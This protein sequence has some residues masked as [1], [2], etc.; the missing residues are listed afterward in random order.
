MKRR[1]STNF[2]AALALLRK[3]YGPGT[4]LEPSNPFDAIVWENCAYLVD[5]ERRTSTYNDL[6]KRIGVT[7]LGLISAGAK[8]IEA[9]ITGGGMKAAH[10][11]AKVLKC[12]EIALQFAGGNLSVALSEADD[13][14][15]RR[16]LKRF[17]GIGDPGVDKLLLLCGYS[18]EPALESNGLRVLERLDAIRSTPSYAASYRAGVAYLSEQN[19]DARDAFALLREHGRALCKRTNPRCAECPLQA[20][21]PSA[22]SL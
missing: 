4:I 5:D 12:A 2:A 13:K 7:P 11:A 22:F 19:V 9:A 18:N 14:A 3:T 10:R 21:C 1:P 17:P 16:L 8:S 6:R 15:R 20:S